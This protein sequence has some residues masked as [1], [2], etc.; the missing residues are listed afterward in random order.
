MSVLK[1]LFGD[2]SKKE[3]KRI[4]PIADKV[5]ALEEKFRKMTDAE[6]QAMT[7]K[8]KDRLAK[9]ETLETLI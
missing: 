3:L 6:L 7:P 5:L 2:Y 1:K 4:R 8:L 9:G